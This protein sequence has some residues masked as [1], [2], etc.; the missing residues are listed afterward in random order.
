VAGLFHLFTHAFFKALLFLGSGS[1]IY[2]CHHEQE[3]T[4]MGGLYPKMR[5][6]ALTM[7]A[8]VLAIAGTPLFSGWHSKDAVVAQSLG[9][10]SVNPN[11][12][13]LFILP[14]ATAGVTTFYMFRMWFLTFTGT[15]RD[16]HVHEHAHESPWPMT[17]PLIVLAFFAVVV[18]WGNRPWIAS[19]SHLESTIH[20]SMPVSVMAEFGHVRAEEESG[21]A[22]PAHGEP[23]PE[24]AAKPAERSER[25]RAHQLHDLAGILA[26]GISLL[27]FVFAYII[28]Y[29]RVLDPAEA[30][31]QF[32]KVYALLANKWYFDALY[33]VCVVRPAMIVAWAF[34]FFDLRVIDGLI[35]ALARGTLRVS[36]IDG[37][38]DN[39][40]VDGLVNLVGNTTYSLGTAMRNVQTGYLRSY[41]LFLVLAAVAI[42][43]L[44][45]YFVTLAT[46]G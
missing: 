1:V 8:G 34:R 36:R 31:E 2:G 9:F 45:S 42:F 26:L 20:H 37:W 27:G 24:V 16:H 13:L 12:A 43:A 18:S 7:L 3:M 39:R 21:A 44:L 33:S 28:Y 22:G 38:I 35:H 32:P 5:I 6:T 11:H 30:K 15:P 25:H 46:A 10:V 14:L 40:I 17:V 41:V 29:R 23:W 19:E 4:K